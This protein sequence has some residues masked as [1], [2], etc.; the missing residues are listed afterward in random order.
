MHDQSIGV[1]SQKP[2]RVK[3]SPNDD[4]NMMLLGSVM[5]LNSLLFL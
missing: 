5:N 3:L 4:V 2:R 1:I